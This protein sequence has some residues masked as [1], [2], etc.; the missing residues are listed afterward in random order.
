[1]VTY[2]Y[3][4]T[5][6]SL[7][8][9]GNRIKE[10]VIGPAISASGSEKG[11]CLETEREKVDLVVGDSDTVRV[12]SDT[13]TGAP[14]VEPIVLAPGQVKNPRG[15]L[16][17]SIIGRGGMSVVYRAR[18]LLLDKP[19]AIKML[20][21]HLAHDEQ[22][23]KRFRQEAQSAAKLEHPGI[24]DVSEFGL[25]EGD[26][27]P[28][29]VMDFVDG[30][31]LSQ[32]LAKGSL[33]PKRALALCGQICDALQHAHTAGVVHR[34]VK[35]SNVLLVSEGTE[36]ERIRVVD[37][38]IAKLLEPS[39]GGTSQDLTRTGESVG[40]PPYMSPEQIQGLPLD[41]RSDI[42]SLGCLLYE[43]LTGQPPLRGA[44]SYE[45]I[46][47]QMTQLPDSVA[48]IKPIL[49]NADALDAL[50]LKAVAKDPAQ[51]YQSMAEF[52]QAIKR[53][54]P[55][56]DQN[57]GM[58][59]RFKLRSE[60][61]WAKN[62]KHPRFP[63]IAGG[64]LI[65]IVPLLLVFSFQIREQSL[66]AQSR[67]ALPLPT[68][69]ALKKSELLLK[70]GLQACDERDFPN[71]E[72]KLKESMQLAVVAKGIAG[73]QYR[74][75]LDAL[76]RLY[77]E[78]NRPESLAET[79]KRLN[80]IQQFSFVNGDVT[81]NTMRASELM[82]MQAAE[83]NNVQVNQDLGEL[84]NQ[85]AKLYCINRDYKDA[86]KI[87]ENALAFNTR[88]F[89]S[90]SAIAIDSAIAVATLDAR[91]MNLDRAEAKF[92]KLLDQAKEK[93]GPKT[94]QTAECYLE[95]G[96]ISSV[97]LARADFKGDSAQGKISFHQGLKWYQLAIDTSRAAFS[98]S[99]P[100]LAQA[101]SG[102][103]VMNNLAVIGQV[104]G[105]L[106]TA[107]KLAEQAYQLQSEVSGK[108]GMFTALAQLTLGDVE[109]TM[110][111]KMPK[112]EKRS[113]LLRTAADRLVE[114]QSIMEAS[115][116]GESLRMSQ[117]LNL[118]AFNEE[119]RGN[120]TEAE[121]HFKRSFAI[122]R[123]WKPDSDLAQH[124]YAGLMRLYAAQGRTEDRRDLVRQVQ[125]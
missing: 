84:L 30:I 4:T 19:V 81:K 24:I 68:Q 106:T 13:Y 118:R 58:V 8:K 21:S 16:I 90:E 33:E 29:L 34:D 15:Y 55:I 97:R 10:G 117:V 114:A 65:L 25:T 124:A 80:E 35:P 108:D 7:A 45:T 78:S 94:W 38:G 5:G 9:L 47:M 85:Q 87:A 37:F 39:H 31:S 43:L 95:L 28:F 51:R 53:L 73:T 42:Y 100:W 2:S 61:L 72:A 6:L 3:S 71:A 44:S 23:L 92:L 113:E 57:T 104:G 123:R 32:L 67:G 91:Q 52:Q 116:I 89:G 56:V 27:I 111:S 120:S 99:S 1:M 54:I 93:I 79:Q 88:I 17:E 59:A 46:T 14:L 36:N 119:L 86:K 96:N 109:T 49:K 40:S 41:V 125:R 102:L 82:A 77:K 63:A 18:H 26:N 107:H 48:K 76:S 75:C 12:R 69:S 20:H 122:A 62:V 105:D 112:G 74:S 60:L 83:P 22:S 66:N 115:V 103:A 110:A 121:K 50:I 101:Y 70:Q 98:G 64:L 11:A